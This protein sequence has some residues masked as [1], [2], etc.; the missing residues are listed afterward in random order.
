MHCLKN[1]VINLSVA[2]TKTSPILCSDS[3]AFIFGS[4]CPHYTN[5]FY[6]LLYLKNDNLN[7]ANNISSIFEYFIKMILDY[8]HAWRRIYSW[9]LYAPLSGLDG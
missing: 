5:T 1:N 9:F 7:K 8:G 3:I 6:L 4:L 2:G